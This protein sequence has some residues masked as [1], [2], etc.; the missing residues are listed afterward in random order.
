MNL[1]GTAIVLIFLKKVIAYT[2]QKIEDIMKRGQAPMPSLDIFQQQIS[3]II[4]SLKGTKEQ[5][6][7]HDNEVKPIA[8]SH[9]HLPDIIL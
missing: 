3:N 6:N 9:I 2:P 7:F 5:T 8:M 4:V 1:K